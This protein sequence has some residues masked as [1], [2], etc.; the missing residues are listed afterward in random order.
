MVS[1]VNENAHKCSHGSVSE[2]TAS[3]FQRTGFSQIARKSEIDS[4]FFIR[5]CY[6]EIF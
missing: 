4:L 2:N 5:E 6:G 3:A 1:E